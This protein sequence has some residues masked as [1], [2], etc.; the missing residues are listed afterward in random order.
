MTE[1]FVGQYDEKD[2]KSGNADR[3]V[4][5]AKDKTGLTYTYTRYVKKRGQIVGFK[6]WVCD[7]ECWVEKEDLGI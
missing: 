3:D 6:V 7:L 1:V 4:Q 5:A 2:V